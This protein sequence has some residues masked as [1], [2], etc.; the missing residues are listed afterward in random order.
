[1][2]KALND[3]TLAKAPSTE[4]V[5]VTVGEVV[6][7]IVGEDG[8]EPPGK[9]RE[10]IVGEAGVNMA[11]EGLTKGNYNHLFMS[12]IVLLLQL[13][14]C[15]WL[16]GMLRVPVSTFKFFFFFSFSLS[17]KPLIQYCTVS[18]LYFSFS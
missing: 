16:V 18:V 6:M 5:V 14:C 3:S 15:F 9:D 10:M 11:P 17:G 4:D 13:S 12:Q 1:M 8:T 7:V 2:W